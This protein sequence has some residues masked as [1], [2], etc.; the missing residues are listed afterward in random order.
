MSDFESIA[1][2]SD[3]AEITDYDDPNAPWNQAWDQEGGIADWNDD[4]IEEFRNNS[5]KVGGAYVGMDLILLTTTGAKSGRRHT[6]PLGPVY[7][8]DTMYVSSFMEDKYPAWWYDVKANPQ[9]TIEL[10]DNTYQATGKVLEGAEYDEFAA[11]VLANNPLLADFQSK[12]DRPI[13]LVVLT[14]DGEG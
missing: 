6:I 3:Q 7:R 12:V 11:W 8:G 2:Q 10:R 14:L 1:G 4:V 9:V 13:P 5:G